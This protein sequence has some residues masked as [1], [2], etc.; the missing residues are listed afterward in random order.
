MHRLAH[1]SRLAMRSCVSEICCV[2]Y[3]VVLTL[4]TMSGSSPANR[5]ELAVG[6][7]GF[8]LEGDGASAFRGELYREKCISGL[9]GIVLMQVD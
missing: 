6:L 3:V 2:L 4:G 1:I 9:R 8:T 7:C 5:C